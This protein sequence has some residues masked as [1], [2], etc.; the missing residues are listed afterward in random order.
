MRVKSEARRQAIIEVAAEAFRERGFD[1]A[2]M[3]DVAARVG[4]SKATLYN[5]FCSK[6]ALFAAVMMEAAK[7]EAGPVVRAFAEAPALEAGL[8]RFGRDYLRVMLKPEILAINR[9]CMAE[10]ERRGLGSELFEAGPK[11]GWT[12]VADRLKRA[13]DKGELREADPWRAGMHLKG[14]LETGTLD[15]RLRGCR[16]EF[17]E[18]EI[19][20]GV[21]AAVDVFLRAYRP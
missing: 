19:D 13:M 8:R 15:Q 12:M 14:L 5:Y 9:M 20:E 21:D 16:R 4:G 6:E 2:S 10:G 3:S 17:T 11:I 1:G 7:R 18:A